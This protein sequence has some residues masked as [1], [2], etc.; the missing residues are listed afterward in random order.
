MNNAKRLFTNIIFGF[1]LVMIWIFPGILHGKEIYD[2]VKAD[3]PTDFAIDFSKDTPTVGLF[4]MINGDFTELEQMGVNIHSKIGNIVTVRVPIDMI[5]TIASLPSVLSCEIAK[6]AYPNLNVSTPFVRAPLARDFFDAN[7]SGVIV[8]I[9]DDAIDITN[10]DFKYGPND[11]RILYLWNQWGTTAPSPGPYNYGTE[12]T[13]DG[14][15][16]GS[17]NLV[18]YFNHGTMVAGVAAGSGRNNTAGVP[19]SAYAGIAY[20]ANIISVWARQGT[21]SSLNMFAADFILD[22]ITYIVDKANNLNMPCVINVSL[23]L[24]SGPRDGTSLIEAA[25]DS[26]L[27]NHTGKGLAIVV[28]AGNGGYDPNNPD[29]IYQDSVGFEWAKN[30]SHN[31]FYGSDTL[32]VEVGASPNN[33]DYVAIDIWYRGNDTCLVTIKPPNTPHDPIFGPYGPGYGT[34]GPGHGYGSSVGLF[35]IHNEHWGAGLTRDPWPNTSDNVIRIILAEKATDG[36]IFP[37]IPGVWQIKILNYGGTSRWDAYLINQ[38][39][40]PSGYISFFQTWT[41]SGKVEEPGCAN[42]VITVGSFNT[43]QNWYNWDNNY[44]PDP[45]N[46]EFME[47]GYT[48]GDISFFSSEGP[49]RDGRPKPDI[50][51]PGA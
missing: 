26:L 28:A 43:K 33:D 40:T 39:H 8:G 45:G 18:D 12:Y 49:T 27:A 32:F 35:S 22:G 14:I 51:A 13:K 3:I 25:I 47:A 46:P 9:V 34:G 30:K 6:K 50:Y 15:D 1:L 4:L 36:S 21:D 42:N 7:G 23:S 11:S 29:V 38:N 5:D 19:D 20:G 31:V 37:L 48:V 10:P 17:A 16:N 24:K 41:N 44:V 2:T